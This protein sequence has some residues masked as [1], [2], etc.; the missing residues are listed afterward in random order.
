LGGYRWTEKLARQQHPPKCP[1]LHAHLEIAAL[2]TPAGLKLLQ[3]FAECV[4]LENFLAGYVQNIFRKL[5]EQENV[6]VKLY[7][8]AGYEAG[9]LI[10]HFAPPL[11]RMDFL[12]V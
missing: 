12:F 3:I 4:Q 9:N 1:H 8:V 7:F 10:E 6:I 2:V 5:A 11:Y